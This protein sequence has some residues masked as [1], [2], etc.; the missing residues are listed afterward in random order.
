MSILDYIYGSSGTIDNVDAGMTVYSSPVDTGA[1][2][3][4]VDAASQGS[5]GWFGSVTDL[6]KSGVGLATSID[7]YTLSREQQQLNMEVAKAGIDNQKLTTRTNSQIAG[8]QAQAQ[9]A[10][11]QQAAN[12]GWFGYGSPLY[13]STGTAAKKSGSDILMLLL[14]IA[15][16]GFAFLQFEEGRK[17]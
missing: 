2:S 11:A 13:S 16:V 6:L 4:P 15:G 7:N 9:L 10:Q 3:I 17:K 1:I 5:G 12:M 14:T 8:L